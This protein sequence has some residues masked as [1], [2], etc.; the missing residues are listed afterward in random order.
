MNFGRAV[1]K[2]LAIGAKGW[3][4]ER[5]ES[6]KLVQQLALV[7]LQQRANAM[8]QERQNQ[9]NIQK[10]ILENRLRMQQDMAR[11]Q[12]D[13]AA[14]EAEWDSPEG[15]AKV[16]YWENRAMQARAETRKTE[17]EMKQEAG[18][19]NKK[20]WNEVKYLDGRLKNL[21]E[22]YA[23]EFGEKGTRIIPGREEEWEML[24]RQRDERLKMLNFDIEMPAMPGAGESFAPAP[25][26]TGE[27][28]GPAMPEWMKEQNDP[29]GLK[30]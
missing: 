1:L 12:Q 11:A 23:T 13:V 6:K 28:Y 19:M 10:T 8:A 24:K 7:R 17:K 21:Q 22:N 30:R 2:G 3:E 9:F 20:T 14:K 26:T 16:D 25:V 15:R 27:M 4:S 29:L 18:D 5:D